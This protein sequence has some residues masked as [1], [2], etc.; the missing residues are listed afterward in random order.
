MTT[1]NPSTHSYDA[2]NIRVLRGLDP[3]RIRPGMYIGDTDDG[4]GLH[5][6]VTEVVDNAV[7][8][9]PEG[10]CDLIVATI[11]SDGSV[12]V[13]DNGRGIPTEIMQG[14]GKDGQGLSAATVIM[15]TLHA[16]AKFDD[17][18][19]AASGG[20]H[21]VGVSVVNAL[22]EQLWMTIYRHG[23]IHYQE[24]RYGE[25]L[26]DL[27]VIGSTDRKGTLIRFKP[28]ADVFSDINF[29]FEILHER[30][31]ELSYLIPGMQIELRDQ[32]VGSE[33]SKIL[34]HKGG[35]VEFVSDI[36]RLRTPLNE[37][38]ISVQG[39]QDGI[40]VHA[41]FQW[42]ENFYQEVT[43]C[44]TNNIFQ[45][46]GGTHMTGVRT[47]VTRTITRYLE[48]Q[49]LVKK[50]KVTGEDTREGLTTVLTVRIHEPKFSSQTKDKLVS[51]NV[52]GVVQSIVSDG[53]HNFLEE[54]PKV[55]R[56]ICDKIVNAAVARER[57]QKERAL[58]RKNAFESTSLPGKLADCQEKDP[59]LSEL[60]LV[61]GES[62]GGS[63]KQA[64][65]RKYQAV[66][67]LKGKILNVQKASVDK[68]IASEEIQTL[69][70]ALGTGVD[71]D[72]DIDK[73][74]Y[75]RVIIMTDADVDGSHIRTLLLTFF[76]KKMPKLI[77]NGHLY[78]AQPPLYKAKFRKSEKYLNDDRELANYILEAALDGA[79]IQSTNGTR[80]L[81]VEGDAL[82]KLCL[83]RVIAKNVEEELAQRLDRRV[84][85]IL[86]T[87]PR[88]DPERF[89]EQPYLE[90]FAG[91]LEKELSE[92]VNGGAQFNVEVVSEGNGEERY[93]IRIIKHHMGVRNESQ[94]DRRFAQSKSYQSITALTQEL[95]EFNTVTVEVRKG[96]KAVEQRS[97]TA[98][99]DWLLD[100]ARRGVSIQRYKGLGE[101]NADQLRETT[102]DMNERLLRRVKIEDSFG[103]EDAFTV[104]M[105]DEV[106]PRREFIEAE[107]LSVRNL[108]I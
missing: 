2:E 16:G 45:R 19:Y 10:Q 31:R 75:H 33:D 42:S 17:D 101:M 51:S 92:I 68:I 98:A 64:R 30:L 44:Y 89:V 67:P 61:E 4:T 94:L 25:P 26:E 13:Q 21:G 37:N 91:Q 39:E 73:L 82:E 8:E 69:I 49:K 104:L 55:A 35:I 58:A 97:F 24:F 12:S 9:A 5:H 80:P 11:H 32:R 36:N 84:L 86:A 48:K 102:M 87:L 46:D 18:S 38:V 34:R 29:H 27:K 88:L 47:A 53:L 107:A 90:T 99:V 81:V 50:V 103:T 77:D 66:L 105:G 56:L 22:S 54:N 6:M 40:R 85:E 15:T 7:D 3:V 71:G 1:D 23:S 83:Y 20:L 52:E 93:V 70:A 74:R 62:A 79:R 72:F 76:Y 100:D 96:S 108:D 95:Q 63:A 65:D 41:A 106:L 28:S 59:A 60:F 14:E 43:R 57:A 78:I